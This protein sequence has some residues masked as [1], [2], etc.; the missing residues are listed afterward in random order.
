[1]KTKTLALTIVAAMCVACYSETAQAQGPN[2]PGG[3]RL[4]AAATG[5]YSDYFGYYQMLWRLYNTSHVPVPPYFSLQPP[6]YYT[7][8]VGRTYGY[9]PYAYPPY[10]M[11]PEA[12]AVAKPMPATISNPYVTPVKPDAK[13]AKKT[14]GN[15]AA[16]VDN[17]FYVATPQLAQR[18]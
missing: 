1:M 6:V 4:A 16:I 2:G 12:K 10:I 3:R 18:D 7:Q 14:D 17:P 9:S 13:Q 15:T 5:Y 8:P 11:T